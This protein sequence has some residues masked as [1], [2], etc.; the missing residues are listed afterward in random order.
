MLVDKKNKNSMGVFLRTALNL[1]RLI[2]KRIAFIFYY[3]SGIK[4]RDKNKVYESYLKNQLQKTTDPERVDRWLNEEWQI[5]LDGFRE[6][7]KRNYKY[8][9][10]AKNAICLG[11]RTGQEVKA[12]IDMGI[13]AIGIDLVPF[14]PYTEKGD[15]HFLEFNENEFDL[16]FTNIF[17]HSIYP[18]IFCA[19]MERVCKTGGIII[20]QLELGQGRDNYAETI[21][22]NPIKVQKMFS[23]VELKESRKT[24]NKFDGMNWEIILEKLSD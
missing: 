8:I 18:E 19:E 22:Y 3:N 21:V 15:I 17:D 13:D 1:F 10:R 5:K 6:I 20:V 12:L 24:T 23:R 9:K 7:F 4:T 2:K 14:L 16:V 11:S